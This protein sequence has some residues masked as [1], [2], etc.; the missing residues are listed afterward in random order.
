[1]SDNVSGG[2][3]AGS[4]RTHVVRSAG[5]RPPVV[6]F[7]CFRRLVV[8]ASAFQGAN[9]LLDGTKEETIHRIVRL[10]FLPRDDQL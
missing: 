7:G 10:F 1:M 4:N 6:I 9:E 8:P 5:R 2:R 3:R